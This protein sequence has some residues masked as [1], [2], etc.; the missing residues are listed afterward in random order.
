MAKKIDGKKMIRN[1]AEQFN[2]AP[3]SPAPAVA[4]RPSG[5]SIP[6][7]RGIQGMGAKAP[8]SGSERAAASFVSAPRVGGASA[9]T[10]VTG[11]RSGTSIPVSQGIQ[12]LGPNARAMTT[13]RPRTAIDES[14]GLMTQRQTE[15]LAQRA[16]SARGPKAPIIGQD[17]G[18][19]SLPAPALRNIELQ[20]SSPTAT[21]IR[22]RSSR[23]M[24]NAGRAGVRLNALGF[25][26]GLPMAIQREAEYQRE[27]RK[28]Q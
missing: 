2:R 25:A 1:V 11:R 15:R 6:A 16:R 13:T 8:R 12:N 18:R 17:L 7:S 10:G 5:T 3:A 22:P 21:N 4:G 19:L 14:S 24:R 20:P 9:S 27:Q 28:K 26:A 23:V